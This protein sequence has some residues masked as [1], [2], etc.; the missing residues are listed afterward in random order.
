MKPIAHALRRLRRDRQGSVVIETAFVAPLLVLMAVG[1]FEVSSMVARQNEL[2][3]GVAEAA[4]VAL[5]ANMGAETTTTQLKSMLKESL[6][7]TDQQ[8]TV[9][10]LFRCDNNTALVANRDTCGGGNSGGADDNGGGNDVV[11]SSYIR[12]RLQDT[13]TPVWSKIGIARPV[14]YTVRRTVQLS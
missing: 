6:D 12:I 13:Y 10:R 1:S 9:T 4:A 5:A 11:V 8:V 3:S 7:L 2:Q 14:T